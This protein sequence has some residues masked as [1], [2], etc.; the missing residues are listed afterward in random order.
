MSDTRPRKHG[1][2]GYCK[3]FR[4]SFAAVLCSL[5]NW[6]GRGRLGVACVCVIWVTCSK[7]TSSISVRNT[8]SYYTPSFSKSTALST[9]KKAGVKTHHRVTQD[10]T[11]RWN[12]MIFRVCVWDK[13]MASEV[14][15]VHAAS[16]NHCSSFSQYTAGNPLRYYLPNIPYSFR[17]PGKHCYITFASKYENAL[18]ECT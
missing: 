16:N 7:R 1:Q 12:E 4:G 18:A 17:F 10:V 3:T 13:K 11:C 2:T 14:I 15:Q 6:S 5:W 8:L 9:H